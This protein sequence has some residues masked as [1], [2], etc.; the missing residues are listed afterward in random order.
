MDI[1]KEGAPFVQAE[2]LPSPGAITAPKPKYNYKEIITVGIFKD[3]PIFV[4]LLSMCSALGVT[5][6]IVNSAGL[7]VIILLSLMMTNVVISIVGT[8]VPDEIRIPVYITIIAAVI[9]LFEMLVQAFL[10]ALFSALGIFLALVVVNCIVLGRAEAFASKNSP[11]A[12]FCDAI[13]YG[14]GVLMALL[15]IS[16]V[17]TFLGTGTLDF[18][19][20][21]FSFFP[22]EFAL[23]IFVQPMGSFLALGMLIGLITTIK[24]TRNNQKALAAKAKAKVVPAKA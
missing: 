4:M 22:Q 24:I 15:V 6:S 5:S 14:T 8:F 18:G 11:L 20:F 23:S 21:A 3:N 13:G 10:P 7:G 17:R 2:A 12:S 1:A 9:T 19:F 16:I